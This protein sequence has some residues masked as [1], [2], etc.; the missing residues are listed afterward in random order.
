MPN[1]RFIVHAALRDGKRQGLKGRALEA[2][3]NER[4]RVKELNASEIR[5]A[6]IVYRDLVYPK[7]RPDMHPYERQ[8]LLGFAGRETAAPALP[9]S[10]RERRP[11][12]PFDCLPK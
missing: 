11:S 6:S 1:V 3:V 2:L 7:T 10:N 8:G 4:V 12:E 9:P 5:L